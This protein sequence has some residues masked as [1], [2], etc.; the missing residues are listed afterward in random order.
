VGC[1][2]AIQALHVPALNSLASLYR[3]EACS[4]AS[5]EVMGEVAHRTGARPVENPFDLIRDPDVDVVVIATPDSYHVD[6]ALAACQ[7]K[8]KAALV[9]KPPALNSRI[10]RKMAEASE[11]SGVPIVMGY[12]HVYDPATRRAK[13]LWGEPQPFRF[14]QFRTFLGPNEKYTADEI[15]QTIRPSIADRWPAL[16]G[17]LDFAAVATELFGSDLDVNFVVAHGLLIGLVIHDIPVMRRMVG[18]PVKVDYAR[19][20][21]MNG[22]LNLVGLS[23]DIILDHGI[24]RT[25][26]Q[27]EFHESKMTDWGFLARRSDLQVEVKFPPTYAAAAPSS[28]KA[29]YEKN[30]MTVE[31]THGGRFETGFR[32]EWKHVHEVVTKGIQPLTSARD[33][34]KDMELIEE[35]TRTMIRQ[36]NS[37]PRPEEA[38]NE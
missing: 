9:E 25:L 5:R 3:I 4:D 8:K 27:A 21:A 13:E 1:G 6:H 11:E 23:L 14:A 26:M 31:E 29:T 17:Q 16:I 20:H 37:G 19:A 38:R 34:V 2:E 22:P 7:A 36:S 15:L 28:L 32:C 18:E 35:I 30:G 12:P 33:A 24:G 10:V